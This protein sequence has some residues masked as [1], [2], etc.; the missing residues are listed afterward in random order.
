MSATV[1]LLLRLL[2]LVVISNLYSTPGLNMSN[3]NTQSMIYHLP[4]NLLLTKKIVDIIL[5]YV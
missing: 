3:V 4:K 2:D 5:Y 1:V